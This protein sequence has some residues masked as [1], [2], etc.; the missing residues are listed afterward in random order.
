MI[1]GNGTALGRISYLFHSTLIWK[2]LLI[3]QFQIA[4]SMPEMRLLKQRKFMWQCH[5]LFCT[6]LSEKPER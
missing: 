6:I 1:A 3:L 2:V 5:L 4:L